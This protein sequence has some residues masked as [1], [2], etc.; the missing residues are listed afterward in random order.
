[1]RI[2]PP[3]PPPFFKRSDSAILR[4]H[5]EY[6]Q[7]LNEYLEPVQVE[8]KQ[9]QLCF[10]ASDNAYSARAFHF[11]CDNKGPTVTLVRVGDNVFGGYTDKSWDGDKSELVIIR[12]T[13]IY[14]K[15]T[16]NQEPS[17]T[18]QPSR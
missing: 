12:S 18:Y 15:C 17:K 6:E 8:G 2:C 1:M 11:A 13:I 16:A 5:T 14:Q 7:K 4:D 10:R 9:W 3:P